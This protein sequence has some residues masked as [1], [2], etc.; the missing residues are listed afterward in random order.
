MNELDKSDP[1]PKEAIS[2]ATLPNESEKVDVLL[3]TERQR[4]KAGPGC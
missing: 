2:L 3:R 4:H 1:D